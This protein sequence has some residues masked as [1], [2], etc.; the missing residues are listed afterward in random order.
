MH[1]PRTC[2]R[3][4]K[5]TKT[6]GCEITTYNLHNTKQVKVNSVVYSTHHTH[7]STRTPNSKY[8]TIQKYAMATEI[9]TPEILYCLDF[10]YRVILN[11]LM[12]LL[13]TK[14]HS[15]LFASAV[16]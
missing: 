15:E 12:I 14:Y 1:C 5:T 8:I 3:L 13:N 9:E 2:Q 10:V 6:F 11:I 16:Q 7:N 4:R